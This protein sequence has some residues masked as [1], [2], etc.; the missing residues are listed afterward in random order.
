MDIKTYA[1]NYGGFPHVAD[2]LGLNAEFLRQVAKGRRRVSAETAIRIER[3]TDGLV[4]RSDLRP[5]LWPKP[6]GAA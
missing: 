1:L 5:D 3:A 6:E 4:T 2:M